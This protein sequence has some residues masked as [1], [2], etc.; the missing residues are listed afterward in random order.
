MVTQPEASSITSGLQLRVRPGRPL[1][2]A[3]R[4]S[5]SK[6]AALPLLAAAAAT[7]R[8]VRVENVPGSEDVQSMLRSLAEYGFPVTSTVPVTIESGRAGTVWR[9]ASASAAR[10]RASYYLVP[11]LLRAYG[12]AN[13]PWPGG[14]SIGDRAIDQHF[15]VYE[16]FGDEVRT[17]A[18]G[19]QVIAGRGGR[20]VVF[21]LPFRSRGATVAA[22]LR[23]VAGG[24]RLE[25]RNPNLS[26]EAT[27]MVAALGA[28]GWLV[29]IGEHRISV[30]PPDG[31][32]RG[33][34]RWAVPGDKIEAGTLAC[35]VAA[36]GGSARIEGLP[37]A[38]TAA[39]VHALNTVGVR[40]RF[41]VDALLVDAGQARLTGR[42][43]SAVAS[44]DP[45]GLDADF[46]PPLMALALGLPGRHGFTDVINPG[47]HG[48][49]LPQLRRF[50]AVIT[51]SSPTS[52]ALVG[53]QRLTGAQVEATDIR[54]GAAL[55][56]A[57]LTAR[58]DSVVSGLDQMRRGYADL[59]GQFRQLGADLDEVRG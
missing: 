17:D 35:A 33:E 58:G 37:G 49:L 45:Q 7:G 56:I 44:L 21:Q 55:L 8:T 38:H 27:G 16:A 23:A 47:R 4:V 40:A 42:G 50:G 31:D 36:T 11:A 19:Y 2:G 34:I 26:P 51:E 52:C 43:L 41:E 29:E 24:C 18:A 59:P 48:N 9:G 30:A 6:N 10:I 46:E 28:A 3:V 54:T 22:V 14:C 32:V 39:L 25:L 57:A 5:G 53:P 20:A 1:C 15:A 12:E 13:L